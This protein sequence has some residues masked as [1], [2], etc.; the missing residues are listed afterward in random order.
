MI[1]SLMRQGLYW[2]SIGLSK[3]CFSDIYWLNKSDGAFGTIATGLSRSLC[4]LIRSIEDSKELWTRLDKTF[5]VIEE[6]HNRILERISSTISTLDPKIS[7]STLS[8]EVVQ[9]EE[10]P[11]S[12]TQSI[13]I[14]ESLLAVTPSVDVLKFYEIYDISSS[15]MDDPEEDIQIFFI[16]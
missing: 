6:D 9:D 11:E 13:R 8:D 7:A 5:G 4:Y 10:E 12:S 15:H 2:V 16:E 14:E 3:E 1:S